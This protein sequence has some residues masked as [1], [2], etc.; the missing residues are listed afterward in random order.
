M[1][2][3]CSGNGG[4]LRGKRAELAEQVGTAISR[5]LEGVMKMTDEMEKELAK[6][7][8]CPKPCEDGMVEITPP[9][10]RARRLPC[11]IIQTAAECGYTKHMKRGL[12]SHILSVMA[13]VEIPR[14]HIENFMRYHPLPEPEEAIKWPV[15]GFLLIGGKHGTGKSFCAACAVFEYL[16]RQVKSP[17]DR[18]SWEN[19]DKTGSSVMWGTA[20]EIAD[21][22][23][24]AARAKKA[25]LTIIDDLG[26]ESDASS[27]LASLRGVIMR[28]YDMTLPTI[29]TTR[30]TMPD[31]TLRYGSGV[32]DQ[33]TEDMR[34]GGRIINCGDVLIRNIP[35]ND[36]KN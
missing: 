29:I 35:D 20:M 36:G 11:P 17:L 23:E 18:R 28:R 27:G 22:R 8:E 16:K 13:A 26:G 4:S 21:C 19:V 33:L 7:K 6:I 30:L 34:D 32:T 9:S 12:Q 10:G 2:K 5:S 1:R 25:L 24:I 14:R 31:I 15:R 3:D